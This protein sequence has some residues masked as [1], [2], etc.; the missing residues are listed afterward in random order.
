MHASAQS[1]QCFRAH[2]IDA[3]SR[4]QKRQILMMVDVVLFAMSLWIALSVRRST[5]APDFYGNYLWMLLAMTAVRVPVFAL[6]GMYQFVLRHPNNQ[7]VAIT[8]KG[9]AISTFGFGAA[10]FLMRLQGVP[11]SI[12]LIEPFVA[13]TL[14]IASREA[15]AWIV[16]RL[17]NQGAPMEPVLIY[18][19]GSAG[20]QLANSLRFNK[21]MRP[22][23]FL[24]RRGTAQPFGGHLR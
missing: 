9:V 13:T 23:A 1:P 4:R 20:L 12:L 8:L 17:T 18:G 5:L 10:V 6:M 19:A 15:L 11:R 16:R 22:A 7:F 21:K 2:M 3:L 14:V 24:R